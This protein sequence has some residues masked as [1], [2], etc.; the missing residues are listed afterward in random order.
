[1]ADG[2]EFVI[3]VGMEQRGIEMRAAFAAP[4]RAHPRLPDPTRADG[5]SVPAAVV[6]G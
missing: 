6:Q 4:L 3:G 2:C 1:M 5:A